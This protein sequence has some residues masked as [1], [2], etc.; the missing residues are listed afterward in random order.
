MFVETGVVYFF[1]V[2][3]SRDNWLVMGNLVTKPVSEPISKLDGEVH[4]VEDMVDKESV[5][6]DK[7]KKKITTFDLLR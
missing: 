6:V 2:R 3:C 4:E 1:I 7:K 5:K